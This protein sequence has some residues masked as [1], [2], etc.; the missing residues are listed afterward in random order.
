MIR[1]VDIWNT[2][3]SNHYVFGKVPEKVGNTRTPSLVLCVHSQFVMSA[4]NDIIKTKITHDV[5]YIINE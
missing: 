4:E 2:C 5:S 1:A 3:S